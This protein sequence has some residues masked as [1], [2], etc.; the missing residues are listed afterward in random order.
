MNEAYEGRIVGD[1]EVDGHLACRQV[2]QLNRLSA[3]RQQLAVRMHAREL[4]RLV[5]AFL[6][7]LF[8]NVETDPHR[9]QVEQGD[10]LTGRQHELVERMN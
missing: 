2:E 8:R 5:P 7:D 9:P 3:E 1:G 10:A 4:E 6:A